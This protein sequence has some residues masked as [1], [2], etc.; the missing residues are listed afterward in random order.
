MIEHNYRP[1]TTSAIAANAPDSRQP[2]YDDYCIN[3]AFSSKVSRLMAE[4][5]TS[6]ETAPF[7]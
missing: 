4:R 6:D 3:E 1:F 5:K 2:R 7:E